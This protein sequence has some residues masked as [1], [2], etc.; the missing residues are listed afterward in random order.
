MTALLQVQ[1]V[2]RRFGG[3]TAVNQLDLTF[4]DGELLS[5]IGPNGAG[6]T[7]LFNLI[8]GHDAPDAGRIVFNGRDIACMP[9]ERIA[10]LG[11]ARTFQHGRVFANLSVR[12][13]VLVGAHTRLDVVR[14]SP[15]IIGPAV[16]LL[17]AL[18]RPPGVARQQEALAAEARDILGLFGERLL[19][20]L[21]D[22]AFSLS[23]A[24]RRRL[25]IARAL[26]LHPRLLLLDEPTAGM[27]ETE[28]AEML[29]I[30]RTL[31][32]RG[33]SIMLIEHKLDLVMALSDRVVVMDDGA[34]IA[35][36]PPDLVRN[37]PA[38]VEAYL[39]HSGV[40]E[41]SVG[42]ASPSSSPSS[43]GQRDLP[44]KRP[45]PSLSRDAGAPYGRAL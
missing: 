3:V 11:L 25:E 44:V 9:P 30:I 21:D 39:G 15:P 32:Q 16:E 31:K 37:D 4:S 42:P 26:A 35:E 12:D 2:V 38:V 24:N 6:K 1:G 13:N 41:G 20:R 43:L 34:K 14:R 18:V 27:N 22:P 23:Y 28:T 5:V 8:T 7:T 45:G 10:A 33:L 40:G 19:P 17:L 36:G 29:G